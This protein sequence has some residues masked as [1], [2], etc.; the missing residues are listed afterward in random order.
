MLN[1]WELHFFAKYSDR[2]NVVDETKLNR[3]APISTCETTECFMDKYLC[4]WLL[5]NGQTFLPVLKF[6]NL[7]H[8]SGPLV[9]TCMVKMHRPS[10]NGNK[11]KIACFKYPVNRVKKN[12]SWRRNYKKREQRWVPW[13]GK[14]EGLGRFTFFRQLSHVSTNTANLFQFVSQLIL[15]LLTIRF[16]VQISVWKLACIQYY[17]NVPFLAKLVAHVTCWG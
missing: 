11:K 5:N 2:F 17:L 15:Q 13:V 6:K 9:I 12:K 8:P 7:R 16:P 3:S 10:L 1:K 14:K 4:C